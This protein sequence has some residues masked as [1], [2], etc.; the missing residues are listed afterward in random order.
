MASEL[1]LWLQPA[2][3]MK[4]M[5]KIRFG[6]FESLK[7]AIRSLNYLGMRYCRGPVTLS[8]HVLAGGCVNA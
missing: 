7:L 1:L 3:P 2:V 5:P 6:L 4:D 8:Q